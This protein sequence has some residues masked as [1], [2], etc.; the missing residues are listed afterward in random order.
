MSETAAIES[1]KTKKRDEVTDTVIRFAGDSGDGMQLTGNQFATE[2]AWAGTDLATLPDYPAEIRAPAGTLFGVS[3]FQIQFGSRHI[4]TPG[5]EPD[6]L[7]AM[8]PAAFKV[9]VK[10]LRPGG[11]LIC[12]SNA[13]ESRNL[14]RAGF[15]GNPLEDEAIGA[16]YRLHSIAITSLT[17]EA[18]S[19]A[20]VSSREAD[21][22]K[23][24]F[25]LG[26]VSWLFDRP[27]EPTID[28]AE[29]KFKKYP[30]IL[31]ANIRALKAGHAYGETTEMFGRA[32]QMGR[33][34][35]KPGTYRQVT[36]NSA[37]ALGLAAAAAKAGRPLVYG[38][39]PITPASDILHELSMYKNFGVRTFQAEDEIAA[40]CATIGASYAG[41]IAVT[42]TSGPGLALKAE[43]LGLAVMTELPLVVIDVQRGGPSTG[44][45]TKTEQADLLQALYGRN[46]ECPAAVVAARTPGDCFYTVYEAVRIAYKYMCPV[47]VL[48]DGYL[49]NGAE[50]WLIPDADALPPID[51]TFEPAPAAPGHFMPYA[52]DEKTLARRYGIPGTP[53]LEHRVGGLEKQDVTGNVNYDP[54]NHE[55]MI[56]LRAEKIRRITA[57]IPPTEIEGPAEGDLL[58]IGW[59]GTYGSILSACNAAREKGLSV[60]NVHLR[61]LNPLPSDL[62]DIIKRYRRVLVPEINAGQL[63]M[64]LRA[65]YCIDAIGHNRVRGLPLAKGGILEA[66]ESALQRARA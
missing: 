25:A 12:N 15:D 19:G 60:A 2:T 48:T 5:D 42:G 43:A 40:I 26:L 52:R 36:G 56:E 66:I 30:K 3:S 23:N 62:G 1:P 11:I 57:D 47:V 18:V 33:A 37:L 22:C 21:R 29:S 50:P 10:D 58:V 13:F 24:F 44:L 61:F 34:P 16:T 53:G 4:H 32:Y 27:L 31:D 28:W 59:G 9:H 6:V 41:A 65:T 64:V 55:H 54:D 39:Y 63:L 45:P 14:Q 7:V 20:G 38:A 35:M 17:R 51:I 46:G 49:G 8:N